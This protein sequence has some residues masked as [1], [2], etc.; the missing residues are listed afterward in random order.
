[1][2]GIEALALSPMRLSWLL[3]LEEH[4]ERPWSE[5]PK[6]I[7]LQERCVSKRTWKPMLDFGWITA[8]SRDGRPG[9]PL[10]L[11]FSITDAGRRVLSSARM[12]VSGYE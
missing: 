10:E 7:G 4:G 5:M 3:F 2:N 12:S 9:E 6:Q 8:E 1:M 11:F